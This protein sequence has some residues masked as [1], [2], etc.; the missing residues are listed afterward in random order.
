M[1]DRLERRVYLL[2]PRQLSPET[3]AV[4]FAKTSR[5]PL[6]FEEIASELT[7]AKSA[8]FHEKWVVGY[9]HASV[10]EHAVLHIAFENVSR[11]AVETIESNRLASYT[12]KSTRYQKWE[13]QSFHVPAE[14][15]ATPHEARYRQACGLLF[16]A[17]Q[18][19]LAPVQALVQ[20]STPRRPDESDERWDGRI[21][22]R[23]VD[24]CRYLLPMA[25]LANVGMTANARVLEHALK[26][27]LAHPLAEVRQIGQELRTAAQ[28]ELPALLKHAEPTGY[29]PETEAALAALAPGLG[30]GEAHEPLRLIAYDPQAEVRVLAAALYPH[31]EAPFAQLES[32]LASLGAAE[33]ARLAAELLGR[34]GRFDIPL[35]ALEHAVY[36]VEAF[37]D[38]GAYFE[39][40]RHRMMTLTPQRLS[41]R[42]GY[43]VPRLIDQAGQGESYRAAMAAAAE[44]FEALAAWNAHV[45]AYVV[46]NAYHRRVVMTLNLRQVYH[47]S[48]LRAAANA[49]FA[50]RRLA[51]GLAELVRQVHPSLAGFLRLP[52]D[53]TRSS[54]EDEHFS[55]A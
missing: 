14:V 55:A 15:I 31:G 17:Y 10:A 26:K 32:H 3:I 8:E 48:E 22:S 38:Q 19:S 35:R 43:A 2:S 7:E 13:P 20:R 46:P 12:E 5:S 6:S 23:Y 45:A 18:R 49:H 11:L 47:L 27:M 33:Q 30:E 41:T 25:A 28:V 51:F 16:E 24:A 53:A 36:T 4:T 34:L 39:L 40:K 1:A 52:E 9:G 44:A 50:M 42:H 29:L 37:L 54:I 21:R